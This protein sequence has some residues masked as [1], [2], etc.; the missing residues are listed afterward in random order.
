[1]CKN[2]LKKTK[3]IATN[4]FLT[5]NFLNSVAMNNNNNNENKNTCEI[6]NIKS[7]WVKKKILNNITERNKLNLIKYNKALQKNLKKNIDDYK[8][9]KYIIIYVEGIDK[10]ITFTNKNKFDDKKII[11]RDTNVSRFK[12]ILIEPTVL[13]RYFSDFKKSLFSNLN[14]IVSVRIIK[15]YY[16]SSYSTSLSLNFSN[17]FSG[18][19]NLKKVI[20]QDDNKFFL[21]NA[22]E[23][24]K[25]CI[26]LE[27]IEGLNNLNTYGAVKIKGLFQNCMSLKYIKGIE[28]WNLWYVRDMSSMF[29]GCSSLISLP[30]ISRWRFRSYYETGYV[31]MS[32][33]FKNCSSLVTL[34]DIS[35]WNTNR[36]D[37]MKEMF[38][39][40]QSLISLPDISKWD[41][42]WL[43][44]AEK[45]F[46]RCYSLVKIPNLEKWPY[47]ME[48][49]D[50]MFKDCINIMSFFNLE[51]FNYYNLNQ[52]NTIFN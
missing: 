34:P 33:L 5:N 10:D 35:N 37:L 11:I 47:R 41:T 9:F 45:M 32:A 23:M 50:A 12:K 31:N 8:R 14:G 48:T 44:S 19:T 42:T 28:R 7:I 13:V 21:D 22:V 39:G 6:N 18:C 43:E 52:D 25:D 15:C 26:N 2:I 51:R 4:I 17:L 20:I 29:E 16:D 36:V 24:F 38:S 30:D 49:A 46:D 1:M 27:Y 3:K 40:C